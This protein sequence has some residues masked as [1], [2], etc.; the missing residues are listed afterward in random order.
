MSFDEFQPYSS[1][2][3]PYNCWPAYVF[4]YNLPPDRVLKEDSMFLT[5]V[6]PGP[7]HLGQDIDIF[8][9]PLIDELKVLWKD[10]LDMYDCSTK[11]NFKRKVAL[12]WI[13]SYFSAYGDL[14]GWGTKGRLACPHCGIDTKSFYLK[15]DRKVVW[16]D[17]IRCF[18]PSHHHF[19]GQKNKFF[20]S[21]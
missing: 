12:L 20:K 16:F 2:L 4:L 21:I 10:G 15:Y 8:L 3:P 5:L 19:W 6:I 1:N 9:Q 7:K 11:T 13:I 14:S 18:L 17:C